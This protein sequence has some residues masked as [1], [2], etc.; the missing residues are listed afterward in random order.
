[1]MIVRENIQFQRGK[2]SKESL[3]VGEEAIYTKPF[4][5]E[6]F[7]DGYYYVAS[8]D[9]HDPK[10]SWATLIR[11]QNGKLYMVSFWGD[12]KETLRLRPEEG[13]T[14]IYNPYKWVDTNNIT[15]FEYVGQESPI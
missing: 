15:G 9:Y 6:A 2:D 3:R 11:V 10:K 14:E 7:E 12:H 4:I 5:F 13:V 1:M 8:D